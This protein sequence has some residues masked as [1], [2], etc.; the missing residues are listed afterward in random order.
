MCTRHVVNRIRIDYCV[1]LNSFHMT[2]ATYQPWCKAI[3]VIYWRDRFLNYFFFFFL[4]ILNLMYSTTR[5][6]PSPIWSS[7]MYIDLA[8]YEFVHVYCPHLSGVC[9][10]IALAYLEFIYCPRLYQPKWWRIVYILSMFFDDRF[11]RSMHDFRP[12]TPDLSIYIFAFKIYM[13]LKISLL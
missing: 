2:H 7:C 12:L 11:S 1:T 9:M 3:G 4:R 8:Y 5:S 10:H 13:I 6:L